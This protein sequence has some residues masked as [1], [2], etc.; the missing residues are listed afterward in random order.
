MKKYSLILAILTLCFS[1]LFAFDQLAYKRLLQGEKNLQ[2]VDLQNLEFKD[3]N[4]EG[5]DFSNANLS[6]AKFDNVIL[7]NV[8]LNNTKLDC[9]KFCD[10]V[11]AESKVLNNTTFNDAVFDNVTIDKTQISNSSFDN[12]VF[13]NSDFLQT[14]IQETSMQLHKINPSTKVSFISSELKNLNFDH[15]KLDTTLV[16][17]CKVMEE[18][19]FTHTVLSNCCFLGVK[20]NV[21][22]KANFYSTEMQKCY[23]SNFRFDNCEQIN[24][25]SSGLESVF[26]NISSNKSNDL[27]ILKSHGAKVNGYYDSSYEVFWKDHKEGDFFVELIQHLGLGLVQF[28]AA[29]IIKVG[30]A[31]VVPWCC[32][33]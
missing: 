20:N 8:V 3:I 16:L 26:L 23:F 28:G 13:N 11:L 27:A 12:A 6:N 5:V 25:I 15:A 10:T 9:T 19:N 21:I 32:I 30:V 22:A 1:S 14:T 18:L 7:S 24:S 4:I 29:S 33:Q 17:Y 2:G 31:T